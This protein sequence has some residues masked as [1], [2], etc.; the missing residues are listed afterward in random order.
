MREHPIL[1]STPMIQSILDGTKTQTRRVINP[2]PIFHP[3]WGTMGYAWKDKAFTDSEFKKSILKFSRYGTT[4]DRL[5]VRETFLPLTKGYM[6]KA[7][8]LHTDL[9]KWK[10]SIFMPRRAS[11]ITLEVV[12]IRTEKIQY[13]TDEDAKAEGISDSIIDLK[14]PNRRILKKNGT[15]WALT[16]AQNEYAYLWDKINGK[17][18]FGWDKNP[19]VFVIEFKRIK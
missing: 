1:F 12:D 15:E 8:Q 17:R 9:V 13:I 3:E 6:Y 16:N 11:R 2:Q 18:N 14:A 7:D 4:G 5:W 10:P 19:W